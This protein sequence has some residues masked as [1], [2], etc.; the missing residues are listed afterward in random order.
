MI[1]MMSESEDEFQRESNWW[2]CDRD[3]NN[4]SWTN[5]GGAER[6]T[7][8]TPLSW[9]NGLKPSHSPALTH[10]ARQPPTVVLAALHVRPGMVGTAGIWGN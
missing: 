7:I 8:S 2:E 4:Q 5:Q 9:Q 3:H 1:R 10:P 6:S